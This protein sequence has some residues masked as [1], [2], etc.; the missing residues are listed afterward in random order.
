[1]EYRVGPGLSVLP[2]VEVTSPKQRGLKIC[3]AYYGH[4]RR[5][6]E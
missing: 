3:P 5:L 1:M 6:L 4:I 2:E